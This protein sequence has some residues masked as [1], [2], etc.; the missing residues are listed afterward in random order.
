MEASRATINEMNAR[1][2]MMSHSF[3]VGF[4]SGTTAT[5]SPLASTS[6]DMSTFRIESAG[7]DVIVV[8]V[9][10]LSDSSFS[11]MVHA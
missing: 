11:F 5:S 1:L 10:A 8:V 3:F 9:A 2:I 6:V 4:H 7:I